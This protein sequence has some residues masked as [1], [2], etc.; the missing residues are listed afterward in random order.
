MEVHPRQP[1][2]ILS[3]SGIPAGWCIEA[4]AAGGVVGPDACGR[5]IRLHYGQ[6]CPGPAGLIAGLRSLRT[7]VFCIA[8]RHFAH[9]LG[10]AIARRRRTIRQMAS[11]RGRSE[12]RQNSLQG[13][14]WLPGR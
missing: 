3:G 6:R 2:I 11:A 4:L 7:P 1:G 13:S 9:I 12:R 14:G 10:S 8:L 5:T